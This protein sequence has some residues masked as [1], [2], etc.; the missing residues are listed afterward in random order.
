MATN[1]YKQDLVQQIRTKK[2]RTGLSFQAIS[3]RTEAQGH[4]VC[5][6]TVQRII[7]GENTRSES[8]FAVARALGI[9]TE[10]HDMVEQYAA[11]NQALTAKLEDAERHLRDKDAQ[12]Q[13][14]RTMVQT[15]KDQVTSLLHSVEKKDRRILIL[16]VACCVMLATAVLLLGFDIIDPNMGY[17][18][19]R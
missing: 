16:T 11:E 14:M 3:E 5:A 8:L 15:E 12:I 2:E 9:E 18:L 10:D 19:G 4:S 17:F 6:R 1:P 7:S 13:S